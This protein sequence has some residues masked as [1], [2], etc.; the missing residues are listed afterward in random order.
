MI[1]T[2]VV[3]DKT[4]KCNHLNKSATEQHFPLLLFIMLHQVVLIIIV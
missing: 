3:V 1:L 2:L 4:L